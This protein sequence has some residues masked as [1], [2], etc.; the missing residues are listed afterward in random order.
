MRLWLEHVVRDLRYA[1]RLLGASPR[2][3]VA[4]V[5][6]LG[7]GIGANTAVFS[8]VNAVFLRGL[9]VVEPDRL[10]QVYTREG[11]QDYRRFM[12]VSRPNYQDLRARTDV[13]SE[14]VEVYAIHAHL[15][16]NPGEAELIPG[17]LVSSN[18]FT[19]LGVEPA[20]GEVFQPGGSETENRET[21]VLSHALWTRE[22]GADPG[23]V[24]R[25]IQ[26]NRRVFQVVGIMKPG[27]VGRDVLSS[28]GFW[29][30]AEAWETFHDGERLASFNDRR[31]LFGQ[32]LGRLAPGMSFDEATRAVAG[33]GEQL[34]AEHPV[35][36]R[37][38]GL[39][40]RRSSDLLVDPNSREGYVRVSGLLMSVV[41]LVLLTACAN[42]ANLLLGQALARRREIALRLA[43]G[44]SRRDLVRRLLSESLLLALAGGG[45]GWVIAWWARQALWSLRPPQLAESALDA[46]FDLRVLVF[47]IVV[48]ALAGLLFGLLP[49]ARAVH[50]GI[51][52]EL[53]RAGL[54]FGGASTLFSL[55]NLL[56]MAQIALSL[57]A[58]IGSGLFL[59]SLEKALDLDLSYKPNG[60]LMMDLDPGKEGYS[61]EEGQAFL[62]H[63][64]EA[65][66]A[67]PGVESV[68]LTNSVPLSGDGIRR[69]VFIEER[70][71]EDPN[72]R[73]LMPVITIDPGYLTTAGTALVAGRDFTFSDDAEAV[74]VA[75]VNE[76]MATRFWPDQSP[77]G[78]RFHFYGQEVVRQVVG[79]TR[80][81]QYFTLGE[82]PR[83]QVY[84]PRQQNA[85]PQMTLVARLVGSDTASDAELGAEL[86]RV[87]ALV[88]EA[89]HE[90]DP[91]LPVTRLRT[92]PET[93]AA[94][95]WPARIGAVLL[96]V[97]AFLALLMTATGIYSVTAY[98]VDQRRHEISIRMAV[99]ASAD[100]VLR[101]IV[102]QGMAVAGLGVLAGMAV[103]LTA[104]KE[105]EAL[106]YG[107]SPRDPHVLLGAALLILG[108]ACVANYLPAR[109]A[110]EADPVAALRH[111][112]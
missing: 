83:V 93:L 44:A 59:Q 106:L 70:A 22:F 16:T 100:A 102:R 91:E 40:L 72:N 84:V 111:E 6:S 50:V 41:A 36:N 10:V 62:T 97:L 52:N 55:R 107:V 45:I 95:L 92:G 51:A 13:F 15:A 24:A 28:T 94:A 5:L 64:V 35:A 63:A 99:G 61:P 69:T 8:L 57:V 78:Q 89:L 85:Y 60:L 2:T 67:L 30:P 26:L 19:A 82:P 21:V 104:G 103:A 37:D 47:T 7:L 81:T 31:A 4:I 79:V 86:E 9:P 112:G 17:Q 105:V 46:G 96:G 66:A 77:L 101:M 76:A 18:Y 71:L 74:P 90:L 110:V 98:Q 39:H 3:T 58:L 38:R 12:G 108:M 14:L 29:V 34:A 54:G 27:F 33:I 25:R 73:I 42:I 32:V 109:R 68:G 88:A 20:H 65:A 1:A 11:R 43:L 53:V 56:V 80:N 75:L 48:T 23:V 87:G 49:A